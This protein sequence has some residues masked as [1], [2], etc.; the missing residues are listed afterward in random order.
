[1]LTIGK[2]RRLLVMKNLL[3]SLVVATFLLVPGMAAAVNSLQVC[4]VEGVVAVDGSMRLNSFSL[5][6]MVGLSNSDAHATAVDPTV[7][8]GQMYAC[9]N[10]SGGTSIVKKKSDCDSCSSTNPDHCTGCC[11]YFCT[12]AACKTRCCSNECGTSC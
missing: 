2:N 9:D 5:S 12:T 11:D 7:C 1:M 10:G 8:A 3:I 4:E 6:D